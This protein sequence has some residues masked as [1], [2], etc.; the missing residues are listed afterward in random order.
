MPATPRN[1]SVLCYAQGFTLWHYRAPATLA[2]LLVPGHFAPLA[3][4]FAT[5]DMVLVSAPGAGAL[6]L[7]AA[8]A[9]AVRLVPLSA[10]AP[11]VAPVAEAA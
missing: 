6:L 11:L 7:V 3:E 1:L 2:D 9:P 8:T 10:A 4:L 5:G